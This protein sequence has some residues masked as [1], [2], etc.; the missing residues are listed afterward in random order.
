MNNN[1][2]ERGIV[3][4]IILIVAALLILSY[5]GINLRALVN[6]PTTQDNIAFTASTTVTVWDKYLKQPATYL[7]DQIFLNLIWGPAID[8]LKNLRDNK[9]DTIQQSAPTIPTP[10]PIPN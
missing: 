7:W 2:H 4:L 6:S 10:Q 3:K 1:T 5:F 9:P 8:N